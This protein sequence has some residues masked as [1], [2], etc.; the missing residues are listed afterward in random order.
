M[1][2]DG[3]TVCGVSKNKF[4]YCYFSGTICADV[5]CAGQMYDYTMSW[6]HIEVLFVDQYFCLPS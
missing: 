3:C 1:R 2:S 5:S 6:E 4:S